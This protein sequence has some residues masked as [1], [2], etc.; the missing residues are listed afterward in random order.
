MNQIQIETCAVGADQELST[1][2]LFNCTGAWGKG[3]LYILD[4]GLPQPRPRQQNMRYG[5]TLLTTCQF[6]F[7]L[8]HVSTYTPVTLVFFPSFALV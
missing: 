8:T 4:F 2:R 5:N 1:P 3:H 7:F 6:P